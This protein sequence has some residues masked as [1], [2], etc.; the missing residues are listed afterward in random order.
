MVKIEKL[1]RRQVIKATVSLSAFVYVQTLIATKAWAYSPDA[2]LNAAGIPVDSQKVV[3]I[4]IGKMLIEFNGQKGSAMAMNGSVPG[5]VFRFKEGEEAII[6]VT[7]TLD[8]ATSIHWHGLILPQPMDGVPG[9]SFAG[10]QPGETFTYRF[11]IVQS[12][13]YWCHSHSGGQEQQG[14]YAAFVIE[15]YKKDSIVSDQDHVVL[16]SDWTFE[17]PMTLIAKLKKQS[18]YFNYQRKTVGKLINEIKASGFKAAVAER[19]RWLKMRMEPTDILDVS[20]TVL[21]YLMNGKTAKSNWS[22][23]FKSGEKIRLRFINGSAMTIFD[24]RIPGLQMKVVQADGQDVHPVDVDEFRFGPGETYDVIVQPKDEK[25]FAI[26][27]EAMDRSGYAMGTLASRP[28]I[29]ATAPQRR[30]PFERSMDDMGMSMAAMRNMP[31]MKMDEK[32]M[33]DMAGMKT[34][35]NSMP[36]SGMKMSM[37]ANDSLKVSPIPG[38][39]PVKHSPDHHGVGNSVVPEETKNRLSEPGTGLGNDGWKV[40]VYTDLKSRTVN[41][42]VRPIDREIELHLTGNMDRYMWSIDGKKYSEASEPI[43]F[44]Y[45]ERVR[46]TLVNDTM[47]EHPMHLHG[48]L[49]D[50]ENG[51]GA[52]LPR[53]HT[54][55]VKPAERVSMAITA[56]ALGDWAF[57]CHM[58]YHMELGMFRVVRVAKKSSEVK[59]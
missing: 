13:T 37:K 54:V 17:S 56:D 27:A 9:L 44:H 42:D 32:P 28:D 10:I 4:I 34:D 58:L 49:M 12:G 59:S 39:D 20:G 36:M 46:L 57:H 45:G 35:H 14:V 25:A 31:G 53:K 48:M 40:L 21:T 5:P 43:L 6:R 8:E 22:V 30:K 55:T 29:K 26:F 41:T 50:L 3:E 19:M 2:K 52:Y 16:L 7:N 51:S 24:V 47:M 38:K 1:N 33:S 18:T 23:L 11:P 15:P